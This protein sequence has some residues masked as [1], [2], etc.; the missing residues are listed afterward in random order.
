MLQCFFWVY[1]DFES[2]LDQWCGRDSQVI[3]YWYDRK[4]AS[5][6]FVWKRSCLFGKTITVLC[7]YVVYFSSLPIIDLWSLLMEKLFY[8][9]VTPEFAAIVDLS[10]LWLLLLSFVGIDKV[11]N[12]TLSFEKALSDKMRIQYYHKPM[13]ILHNLQL[14]IRWFFLLFLPFKHD[15]HFFS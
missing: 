5:V 10:N 7:S 3:L 9:F 4:M 2:C 1:W 11:N 14:A 8:D 13:T 15:F 6:H 12:G